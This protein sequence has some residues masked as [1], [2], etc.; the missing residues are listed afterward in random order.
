[1]N[2][3]QAKGKVPIEAEG[4]TPWLLIDWPTREQ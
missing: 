4:E 3:R 2:L 1:M